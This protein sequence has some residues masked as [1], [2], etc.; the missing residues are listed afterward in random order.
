M[1]LAGILALNISKLVVHLKPG[2]DLVEPIVII[3]FALLCNVLYSLG[4]ITELFVSKNKNYGSRIFKRGLYLT[5]FLVF[6]PTAIHIVFWV[7]MKF[8]LLFSN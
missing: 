5:L 6:L 8:A 1:L 3:L 7:Y 2:E 4:W